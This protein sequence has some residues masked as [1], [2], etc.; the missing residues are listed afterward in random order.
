MSLVLTFTHLKN[1]KKQVNTEINTM[2]ADPKN[3]REHAVKV[4]MTQDEITLLDAMA[5]ISKKQ[6][7]TLMYELLMEA[8]NEKL[9]KVS[10]QQKAV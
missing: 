3:I 5:N 7:A 10:F 4:R 6:R 2:Y 9:N 8:V 1:T